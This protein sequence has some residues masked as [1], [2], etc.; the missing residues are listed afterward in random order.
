MTSTMAES[1]RTALALTYPG[2]HGLPCAGHSQFVREAK[3][4]ARGGPPGGLSPS[5]PVNS[6]RYWLPLPPREREFALYPADSLGFLMSHSGLALQRKIT[7]RGGI[8]QEF[9]ITD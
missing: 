7:H 8:G 4:E 2:H 5:W 3:V 9:S 1:G 6:V